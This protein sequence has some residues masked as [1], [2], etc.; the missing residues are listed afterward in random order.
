MQLEA[1]D[2]ES[3]AFLNAGSERINVIYRRRNGDFGLI[4]P[5]V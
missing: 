1:L 2:Y 3:L 5:V 4:D